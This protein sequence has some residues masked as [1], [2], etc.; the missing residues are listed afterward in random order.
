MA[1]AS[2]T[3][4]SGRGSA[5][6]LRVSAGSEGGQPPAE[7][8]LVHRLTWE[9]GKAAPPARIVFEITAWC[10]GGAASA[11]PCNKPWHVHC[12]PHRPC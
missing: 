10:A 9:L 8:K 6:T 3:M 11:C 7:A 4:W 1:Q 5:K 2:R 12:D